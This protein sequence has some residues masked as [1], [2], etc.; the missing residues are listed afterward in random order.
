VSTAVPAPPAPPA[1][2]A[3]LGL[4]GPATIFLMGL[5]SAAL[6]AFVAAL[7]YRGYARNDS[8]PM[9]YLAVGVAFVTAIPFVLSYGVEWLTSASDG[10]V[11]LVITACNLV[12]LTAIAYSLRRPSR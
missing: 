1:A 2:V 7:A 12:G 6:G 3:A 9:L 4:D 11:V 8:G 10:V 5:V